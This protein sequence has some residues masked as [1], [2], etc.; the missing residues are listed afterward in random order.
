MV[1]KKE[2]WE[3]TPILSIQLTIKEN[4]SLENPT[5]HNQPPEENLSKP[6]VLS[7]YCQDHIEEEELLFLNPSHQETFWLLVHMPLTE[8]HW[9]ESTQLTSLPPQL[10]SH[11]LELTLMLMMLSSKRQKP[12]LKVNWRTLQ[13]K[14]SKELNNQN[15]LKLNGEKQPNKLKRQ[16]MLNFWPTSLKLNN[17]RDIWE[18]DSLFTTTPNHTNWDFDLYSYLKQSLISN[19]YLI[20]KNFINHIKKV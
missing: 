1:L 20:L 7:F 8:F 16:L 6:A 19:I 17:S 15:K 14:D 18:P 13:N 5:S 11:W 4:C 9:K 10:K 2:D 12:G 3:T